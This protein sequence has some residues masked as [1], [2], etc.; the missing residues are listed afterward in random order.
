MLSR[1][2]SKIHETLAPL[3]KNYKLKIYPPLK[4]DKIP[5]WLEKLLNLS[6]KVSI[7]IRAHQE[8]TKLSLDILSSV[9]KPILEFK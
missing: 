3:L 5:I 4:F 8:D 7:V 9:A 2:L 1:G 6:N